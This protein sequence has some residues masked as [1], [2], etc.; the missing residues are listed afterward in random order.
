[1]KNRRKTPVV[2][3]RD[4]QII[5]KDSGAAQ[6]R[7][8]TFGDVRGGC[9]SQFGPGIGALTNWVK[10]VVGLASGNGDV[11]ACRELDWREEGAS[12]DHRGIAVGVR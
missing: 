4:V 10:M 2:T 9:I 12:I 5:V 3:E 6:P 1:M 8:S 11:S 7:L